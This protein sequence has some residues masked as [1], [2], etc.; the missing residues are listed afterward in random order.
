[1]RERQETFTAKKTVYIA[2]DGTEFATKDACAR[3]EYDLRIQAAGKTVLK[4]PHMKTCPPFGEGD[5]PA[6]HIYLVNSA[7]EQAAIREYH[8]C[9]DATADEYMKKPAYPCLIVASVYDDDYGVMFP[10]SEVE[11]ELRKF[12]QT[13]NDGMMK[14]AQDILAGI[15]KEDEHQ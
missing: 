9:A 4:I 11:D 1:M 13:V 10:W 7:E 5:G 6:W 8:Y 14:M 12:R 15:R 2:D 3:Y